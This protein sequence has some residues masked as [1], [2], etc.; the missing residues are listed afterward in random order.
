MKAIV[1]EWLFLQLCTRLKDGNEMMLVLEGAIKEALD[2]LEAR[3]VPSH[4][5]KAPRFHMKRCEH[6]QAVWFIIKFTLFS[7]FE[8]DEE[9]WREMSITCS[10]L[11]IYQKKLLRRGNRSYQEDPTTQAC[12]K[13]CKEWDEQ[14]FHHRTKRMETKAEVKRWQTHA[15]LNE[16]RNVEARKL[17]EKLASKVSSSP[18]LQDTD[19]GLS[20]E[21][22]VRRQR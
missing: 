19:V 17:A 7:R 21:A 11:Y 2:A 14:A 22:Q 10:M 16:L 12:L 20:L 3:G 13:L 18:T 15:D 6:V 5:L 8:D 9:M 1:S 4:I